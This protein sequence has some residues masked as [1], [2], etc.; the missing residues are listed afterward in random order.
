MG[1]ATVYP[2]G[3]Y[4]AAEVAK[5]AGVSPRRI[6]SWARAGIIL[7]SVSQRPN[8][9]SYADAGE[10]VL[11]H[12]LVEQG[13]GP[14]DVRKIVHGLRDEFGS[15]PLATAPLKHDG[16]LA[17]IQREDGLYDV[18]RQ[19]KQGSQAVMSRTLLDLKEIRLA[20]S[21]GGWVSYKNP[22]EY[23]EV[24]PDRHSGEPVLR[25]RRLAVSLVAEIAEQKHGREELR[26]DYLL[27]DAEIDDAV[28]YERDLRAIAG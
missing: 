1:S 26:E 16:K 22:R 15:W 13:L 10:A 5:L 9:Y 8:V 12:Y 3:Y 21:R 24:D 28:G 27:S 14:S 20:L 17:L 11:A 4:T 7:P 18:I 2:I 19:D 23:I 25:G 6:G